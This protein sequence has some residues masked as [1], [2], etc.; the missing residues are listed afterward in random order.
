VSRTAKVL[1]GGFRARV[2]VAL[3]TLAL[4]LV[5]TGP[6]AAF[7]FIDP[8]NQD[9]V[10]GGAPL[11]TEL[12]AQDAVGLGNQLHL[13]N[14][15][16]PGNQ[17]PWTIIPRLTLQEM[18][19]DNAYE[20]TSPRRPDAITIVA[21]G[22]SIAGDTAHIK[23]NLDYQPNLLLHAINGPLNVI[24]QQ[25]TAVGLITVV[26]NFAYVDVRAL[27]GVQSQ[28]GALAGAGTLGA[29]NVGVGAIGTTAPGTTTPGTLGTTGQGL[30]RNNEVQ[31][32]TF[33][34]SP[35]VIGQFGDYGS[36]KLGVSAN[37]SRYNTI[38]GFVADPL[39]AGGSGGASAFTTEE[40]AHYTSGQFLAKLQYAF[41]ADIAQSHNVAQAGTLNVGTTTVATPAATN[42]SQRETFSN[43]LSYAVNHAFS[44][45]G[46]FGY[47][48]IEYT[49]TNPYNF[50]GL[51]WNAGFTYAPGPYTS[52]TMTYG[53]QNGSNAFQAN[54]YAQIAKR[55]TL[56]VSY[57]NS[58]GTQLENLQNQLNASAIGAANS[59]VNV[60][61]G[62][63]TL[64]ANNALGVQS[65]VFRFNTFST[66]LT[67]QWDRDT[68]QGQLAWT[69]QT[70]LTPGVGTPL[71][72]VDSSGALIITPTSTTV[73]GPSTTVESANLLWTHLMSPDTTLST[74]AAYSYTIRN[75]GLNDSSFSTSVALQYTLSPN[76]T[77]MARYSFFDRISKIP[78]YSL[79]ENILLLSFTKQF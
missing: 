63:P 56:T 31:T 60:Q 79:Y 1:G 61:T 65:G 54:G 47:Q 35:Y 20:V 21:P 38:N 48:K 74:S 77:L 10:P 25:L 45:L 22:I 51:I 46:S 55:S 59:L 67:T 12:P 42:D 7:P 6:A 41:D 58:V 49:G 15:A 23:L 13:V 68:F 73:T 17:T 24:T 5:Q 37:A 53:R 16:A 78:G 11:G 70:S 2:P 19:T 26:P 62:G 8:T 33:G 14:P 64:I 43:Q 30:N 4:T 57:S 66:S 36:G 9:T 29:G 18:F 34:I 50:S 32:S 39:P 27:S 44:L 72:S 71:I 3:L 40:I 52:I 69:E 75:A 28:L 76:T